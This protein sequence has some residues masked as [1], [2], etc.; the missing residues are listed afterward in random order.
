[1]AQAAQTF[2]ELFG[3]KSTTVV[4]SGGQTQLDAAVSEAASHVSGAG[5]YRDQ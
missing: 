3:Y 4:S 5:L 1:M 2:L